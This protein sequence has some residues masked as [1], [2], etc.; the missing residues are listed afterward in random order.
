MFC[1]RNF[2]A[3]KTI[4]FWNDKKRKRA[5]Y[6]PAASGD[7]CGGIC[8]LLPVRGR[9]ARAL[10]FGVALKVAAALDQGTL[11]FMRSRRTPVTLS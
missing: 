10:C 5:R 8:L 4:S 3:T 2:I 7:G 11:A 6:R 9:N 1:D